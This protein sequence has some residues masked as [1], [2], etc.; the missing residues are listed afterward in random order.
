[1]SCLSANSQHRRQP[2]LMD[3]SLCLPGQICFPGLNHLSEWHHCSPNGSDSQLLHAPD[4]AIRK[5]FSCMLNIPTWSPSS[6]KQLGSSYHC[7]RP[8]PLPIVPSHPPQTSLLVYVTT[9]QGFLLKIKIQTYIVVHKTHTRS[10]SLRFSI[11]VLQD[12]YQ[13]SFLSATPVFPCPPQGIVFIFPQS[14]M[15]WSLRHCVICGQM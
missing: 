8:S 6:H 4:S 9:L 1:M 5:P 11:S 13:L 12:P 3:K 14:G 7:R 15:L 10:H 2:S